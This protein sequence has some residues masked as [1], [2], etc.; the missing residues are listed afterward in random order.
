M[1]LY[2]AEMVYGEDNVAGG[3]EATRVFQVLANNRN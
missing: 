1:R 2:F 3:G